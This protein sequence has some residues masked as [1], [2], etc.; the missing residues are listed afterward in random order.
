[1][2]RC[3]VMEDRDTPT[4]GPGEQPY[5][6]FNAMRIGALVGGIVGIVTSALLGGAFVLLLAGAGIGAVAGWAWHRW[7]TRG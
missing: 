2:R 7:E 1:M 5:D 3:Q 4:Y 6:P